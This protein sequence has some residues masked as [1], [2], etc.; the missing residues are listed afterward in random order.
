MKQG[1]DPAA[2]KLPGRMA[3]DPPLPDGPLKGVRLNNKAQVS[4]HWRAFGWD[5]QSGAP[6]PETLERLGIGEL[7]AWEET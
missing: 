3:G 2:V 5:E 7:L 1:V 4:A 6:L